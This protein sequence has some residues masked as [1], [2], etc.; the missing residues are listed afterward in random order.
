MYTESGIQAK[1]TVS[2]IMNFEINNFI[3][4]LLVFFKECLLI[5]LLFKKKTYGFILNINIE[6]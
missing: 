3:Y 4:S 5:Y 2:V 1:D 6:I